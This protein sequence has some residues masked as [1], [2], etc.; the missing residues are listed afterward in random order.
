MIFVTLLGVLLL[1]T[2]AVFQLLLIAGKPLGE[3]AWGGQHKVLPKHLRI[4]SMVS[5]LLYIVFIVLLVSK[6]GLVTIIPESAFLTTAMW[7]VTVYMTVGIMMNAISRSKKE[8]LV[9]TPVAFMLAVVFL[10]VTL[11]A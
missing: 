1:A 3:Y 8:R 4:G 2:L 9:M 6:S 11:G 7:I 10:F 5:I